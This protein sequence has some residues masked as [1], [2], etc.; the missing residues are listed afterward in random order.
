MSSLSDSS[1]P[2]YSDNT[3]N[4]IQ[5][6]K[7][8]SPEAKKLRRGRGDS[9]F[10]I[11]AEL[12][13][14]RLSSLVVLTTGSGF[15]AAGPPFEWAA[16]AAVCTGTALCA[17]SANTFNQVIERDYDSL[18]KRTLMRPLPSGRVSVNEAVAWGIGAGGVGTAMLYTAAGPAVAVL[19]AGNIALYAG[20]YTA[21]K[22]MGEVNTWVG[23]VVGAVPPVMGWIAATHGGLES[24]VDAESVALA[25]LLFLWQ[26]P[27]FFALSYMHREDY[28][29]GGFKMVACSDPT[30]ARSANLVWD[31]SLMLS[32][33]PVAA[34]A[35]GLTSSM[36]AVEGTAANAY[37][38]YLAYKFKQEGG[39]SSANAR[40]VFLCSLWYLP[41]LLGGFVFHSRN[42]DEEKIKLRKAMLATINQTGDGD[43]DGSEGRLVSLVQDTKENLKALCV[44]EVM[45]SN[46]QEKEKEKEKG[47][48]GDKNGNSANPLP[49]DSMPSLCPKVSV[50]KKV[51]KMS[52]V[53]AEVVNVAK[54]NNNSSVINNNS[55]QQSR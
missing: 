47:K 48:G 5:T 16:M 41:L 51:E 6:I 27:H 24:I 2:S 9:R 14:A 53:A 21:S 44:H 55:E 31:Y 10:G 29:R 28:T 19:G 13:K 45:I 30:G 18:M 33:L 34:W 25:S 3:N 54:E 8:G 36:F 38:L 22:R 46:I 32:A 4:D 11:Y 17:A 1:P 15:L 35:G 26:F 50:E 52:R 39:Q 12:S 20:L 37:L 42:W 40:K 43:G 49:T 7:S 23:A